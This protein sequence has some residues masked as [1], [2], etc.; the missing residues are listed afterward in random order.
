[1]TRSYTVTG[2]RLP[3]TDTTDIKKNR[4]SDC[5]F[6]RV[7]RPGIPAGPPRPLRTKVDMHG[8]KT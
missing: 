2:L 7:L 5:L 3:I 1:M 8:S 4:P 6:M